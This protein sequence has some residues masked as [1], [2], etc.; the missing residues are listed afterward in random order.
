MDE[1]RAVLVVDA[2]KFSDHRHSELRGLKER[3]LSV[4]A[5]ACARSGLAETWARTEFEDTGDGVLAV[6]PQ[7]A[8]PLLIDPFVRHVQDVLDEMAPELRAGRAHLRLRVA[9]HCG[10]AN[11]GIS[12]ATIEASRLLESEPLRDALR[13]S[14]PDVT[15]AALL[16][17][18]D[19]FRHYVT[20][21]LVKGLRES[22]FTRVE[23][24]VKQYARPAYLYVPVPSSIRT[25]TTPRRDAAKPS[26]P[27]GGT[28]ISGV[29]ITGDGGQIAFGNTVGGDFR[30]ERS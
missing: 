24:R 4:L 8:T 10:L 29:T 5:E 9:L 2:E 25:E 1:F 26:A 27:S 22:Q 6:L 13:H 19:V 20:G 18:D 16:I 28:S 17:S 23:A 21:G 7:E 12:A 11:D 3:I 14:D 15:Y 30:Q